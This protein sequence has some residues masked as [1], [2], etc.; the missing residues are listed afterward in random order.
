MKKIIYIILFYFPLIFIYK[1]LGDY[2]N[3]YW[4]NYY[5][6][7]SSIIFGLLF[8]FI[9]TEFSILEKIYRTILIS[10]VSYWGIMAA[11]RIFL[12]FRIDLYKQL[13]SSADKLTVG[14][15]TIVKIFTLITANK[16]WLRK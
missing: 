10:T 7:V 3:V 15:V 8:Y 4:V 2:K 13:I 11:L 12:F 1:V 6:T 16:I 5:W 14:A 9:L